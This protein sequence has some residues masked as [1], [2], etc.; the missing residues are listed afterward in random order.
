MVGLVGESGCGK[1]AAALSILG[2]LPAP[3]GRIAG[4]RIVFDGH[5][6]VGAGED[7]LRR[8]RGNRIAMV[9]QDPLTSLNP[10]LRIGEQLVEVARLHL[11]LSRKAARDRALAMLGRVGIGEPERRLRAYPHELS[12][13]MCQRAVIA[14]ALLCDPDLLIAD[15]PTTALDVTIQAQILALLREL[16]GER[17]MAVMLISHDL[18]VVAGLCDRVVVMYAG[19]IVEEAPVRALFANPAHPYT[20]A[21]LES[22]PRAT[23]LR[24]ARLRGI[25][26]QPPRLDQRFEVCR[27]EPRCSR[28][29]DACRAGEPVLGVTPGGRRVRCVRPLGSRV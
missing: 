18:G 11:G 14:M 2:L 8:I 9:F 6:L 7:F 12:G 19:Q 1:T 10:Y 28:A 29:E 4:G 16:R 3:E 15:E 20:A 26:G 17:G 24:R 25:E 23:G 13:G 27:F 5:D 21:L 22:V